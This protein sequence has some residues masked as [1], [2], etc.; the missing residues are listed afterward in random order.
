MTKVKLRTH[1]N[2]FILLYSIFILIAYNVPFYEKLR[3]ID[4]DFL[5]LLGCTIVLL[6]LFNIFSCL[7][8]WKRTTKFLAS[9]MIIFNAS[10]LYF[11]NTYNIV[12]DKVMFLNS[13]ETQPQEILDLLS[14]KMLPYLIFLTLIPI[15]II[16]K[17]EIIYPKGLKSLKFKTLHIL[18]SFF[19][20]ALIVFPNFKTTAQ[21]VR[22]NRSI[23]YSIIPIN[24]FAAGFSIAKDE[25]KPKR[26]FVKIGEDAKFISKPTNSKKNLFV[27]VVGETARAQNFS[28]GGYQQKTNEPLEEFGENILYFSDTTSCGTSTAVSVPCMFSKDARTD[29]KNGS[30]KYTENLL[31]ILSKTGYKVTWVENNSSCKR[32]CDRVE[33]IKACDSMGK[34]NDEVMN[35]ILTDKISENKEN[36]FIVLHQLGSHGPTYYKRFPKEFQKFKPYCKTEVLSDCS[37]EEIVNV[38]DNTIYYTSHNL[39]ENIKALESVSKDYN[40]VLIYVSDHGES[41]GEKGLYLHGAPYI[42][43]PKEQTHVPFFVWMN[44]ET[45]KNL[46]IDKNC[47]KNKLN[48]EISQDYIFHS[49]LSM[50]GIRTKEYNEKLDLFKGCID[51]AHQTQNSQQEI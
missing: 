5:F 16:F 37:D 8:F 36:K 35:K 24:Y 49:V 30:A 1:L 3:A 22:N 46:N 13:I 32:N 12:I 11:V 31:D 47:L 50:S 29:Y 51:H 26:A 7:F 40:V 6:C 28:L 19:I 10:I 15:F 21:F 33:T 45:A 48:Q 43:A 20:I 39:A 42:F 18:F 14:F 17:T 23:R 25:L 41:L 44:D 34:C 27:F 4:S 38:Y 2:L 9:L